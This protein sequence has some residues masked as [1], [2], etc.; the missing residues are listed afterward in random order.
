MTVQH[1]NMQHEAC[2]ACGARSG[3][4]RPSMPRDGE[5]LD[6][7]ERLSDID[8]EL[9]MRVRGRG[10]ARGLDIND[11]GGGEGGCESG[12]G[13]EPM[14]VTDGVRD[15]A[16]EEALAFLA[17]HEPSNRGPKATSENRAAILKRYA[18]LRAKL[19]K[20]AQQSS[21][22]ASSGE[23]PKKAEP[24]NPALPRMPRKPEHVKDPA[25]DAARLAA[26]MAEYAAQREEAMRATRR[27]TRTRRSSGTARRSVRESVRGVPILPTSSGRRSKRPRPR[28]SVSGVPISPTSSGGWSRRPRPRHSVCGVMLCPKSRV[29][30]SFMPSSRRRRSG[31]P[32][33]PTSSGRWSVTLPPRRSVHGA[34][35]RRS[36]MR[37]SYP[38][39]S[40]RID[41]CTTFTR[42]APASARSTPGACE[43]SRKE[44]PCIRNA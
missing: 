15:H 32:I 37:S 14:D 40:E 17:L 19:A 27:R 12:Q 29:G 5:R 1:N 7:A 35:S 26:R 36:T 41:C 22:D 42:A 4:P 39:G 2:G 11:G 34:A 31:V 38:W 21:T 13:D 16:L 43:R 28:R 30:K 8:G 10:G 3:H 23:Q 9:W 20:E 33:S 25:E 6:D 24:K 44:A 18:R